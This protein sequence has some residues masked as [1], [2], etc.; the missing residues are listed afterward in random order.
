MVCSTI[1]EN[2]RQI[3]VF[4]SKRTQFQSQNSENRRKNTDYKIVYKYLSNKGIQPYL[5][6][7]ILRLNSENYRC[8]VKKRTQTKPIRRRLR[9][10]RDRSGVAKAMPD[11]SFCIVYNADFYTILLNEYD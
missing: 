3:G 5:S 6:G 7:I 2:I 4:F 9:L 1:V 8:S 10:C 11:K